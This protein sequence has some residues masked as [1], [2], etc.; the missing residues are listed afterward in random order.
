M[1]KTTLS[2]ADH[3]VDPIEVEF[4]DRAEKRLGADE[5]HGCRNQ[6]QVVGAVCN[7]HVL[8]GCPNPDVLRPGEPVGKT[9][10]TLRSLGEHLELMP[11]RAIH[12]IENALNKVE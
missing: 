11:V 10:G 5:P 6:R 2:A 8:D 3:P 9:Q 7:L 12:Y 4:F 1:T